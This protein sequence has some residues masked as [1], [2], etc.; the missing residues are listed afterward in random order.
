VAPVA[1]GEAS[2]QVV[3]VGKVRVQGLVPEFLLR[4][5][6]EADVVAAIK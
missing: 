6:E 4:E 1:T 5:L 2:Y 3:R